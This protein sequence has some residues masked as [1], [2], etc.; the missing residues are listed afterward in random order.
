[1]DLR[2]RADGCAR[3]T[4]RVMAEARADMRSRRKLSGPVSITQRRR[5]RAEAV[6][7]PA[8]EPQAAAD[9]ARVGQRC[10]DHP[11]RNGDQPEPADTT[12][13]RRCPLI[14]LRSSTAFWSEEDVK[15][16]QRFG[17]RPRLPQRI[18][19]QVGGWRANS[20]IQVSQD[21]PLTS[22]AA[23]KGGAHGSCC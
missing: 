16:Q 2:I 22:R 13:A 11:D 18:R 1:M 5:A 20:P 4:D 21:L 6:A 23:G 7:S 17:G 15:G 14:L 10:K 3:Y 8:T 9:R 12:T 19:A